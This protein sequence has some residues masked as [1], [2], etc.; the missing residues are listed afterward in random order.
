MK[1]IMLKILLLLNLKVLD[2]I[3]FDIDSLLN[4]NSLIQTELGS[5]LLKSK[6]LSN[7][8]IKTFK[9]EVCN[10]LKLNIQLILILVFYAS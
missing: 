7:S 1:Y 8:E 2:D 6:N 5:Y 9:L 10:I 4:S 3:P